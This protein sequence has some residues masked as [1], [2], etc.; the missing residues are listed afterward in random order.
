MVIPHIVSLFKLNLIK[1][2]NN[3]INLLFLW[4]GMRMV[5]FKNHKLK[6]CANAGAAKRKKML[7]ERIRSQ[8]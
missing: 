8:S 6:W 1:H 4:I 5:S 7:G 3:L 2:V